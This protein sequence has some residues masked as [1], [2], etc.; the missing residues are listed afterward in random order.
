MDWE[1][2]SHV[3]QALL[4]GLACVVFFMGYRAGDKL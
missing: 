2:T 3:M 1:N 4:V